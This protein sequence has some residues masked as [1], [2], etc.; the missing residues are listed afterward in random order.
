MRGRPEATTFWV[1]T[2]EEAAADFSGVW[3]PLCSQE[4]KP[5]NPGLWDG[6]WIWETGGPRNFIPG[7]VLG[8]GE[9]RRSGQWSQAVQCS[10][11]MSSP[12]NGKQGGQVLADSGHGEAELKTTSKET[13]AYALSF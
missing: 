3:A 8:T 7:P 13:L 4:R 11:R 10:G 1:H 12:G 2:F 5:E 6:T 9:Q